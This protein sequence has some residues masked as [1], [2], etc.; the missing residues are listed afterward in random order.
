MDAIE[1]Y[2]N[3]KS[4]WKEVLQLLR[5]TLLSLELSETIKWGSPVYTFNNKNVVGLAA[6]KS[7]CGLWFFQGALLKDTNKV[8]IN[9]Q[10]G[11][12]KAM[13]QWR[14]FSLAEVDSELIKKYVAE[15]IE[16]VK[17]G[18]EIKADRTKKE[19][20]IPEDLQHEID[21]NPLFKVGFENLSHSCQREYADYVSEAK[22]QETRIKRLKKIT[23]MILKGVSLHAAYKNC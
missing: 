2:I 17:A 3:T 5:K 9:A 12:T 18:K 14:F 7:Y 13:L 1:A 15:A 19:L 22:K 10:E 6:F 8:F 16:N 4:E 21:S 20:I 11:K 23:P